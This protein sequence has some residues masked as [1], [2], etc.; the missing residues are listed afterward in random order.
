MNKFF[1]SIFFMAVLF[2]CNTPTKEGEAKNSPDLFGWTEDNISQLKNECM[3]KQGNVQPQKTDKNKENYCNCIVEKITYSV[4]FEEYRSHNEGAN[5]LHEE[6]S[7]ACEE[8]T[9][10][11]E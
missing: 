9:H 5:K 11:E 8:L 6:F 3:V 4:K 7:M 2:S 1:V 10:H